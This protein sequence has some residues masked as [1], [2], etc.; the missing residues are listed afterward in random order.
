MSSALVG[1]DMHDVLY[2]DDSEICSKE[3][4]YADFIAVPDLGSF[5]RLPWEH[6]MPFFKLHFEAHGQSLRFDGRGMIRSLQDKLIEAGCQAK[7][8]GKQAFQISSM[9]EKES[10]LAQSNSSS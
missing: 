5:R 8:G 3:Q 9:P 6:D 4:G 1:W 2:D 10:D 7:A